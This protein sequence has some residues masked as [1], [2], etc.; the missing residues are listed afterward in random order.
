M[1]THELT[2]APERADHAGATQPRTIHLAALAEALKA[3]DRPAIARIFSELADETLALASLA[4]TR[5]LAG[6]L[7]R[8]HEDFHA[9]A[10]EWGADR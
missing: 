1:A 9:I 7:G 3:G 4:P 10:L 8:L 5:D 6:D 2:G